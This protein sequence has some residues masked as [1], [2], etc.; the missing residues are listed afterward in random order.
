MIRRMARPRSP[1]TIASRP[2]FLLFKPGGVRAPVQVRVDADEFEALRLA[3]VEGLPH[4]DAAP[5]MGISRQTFGRVLASARR[6]VAAALVRGFALRFDA[7]PGGAAGPGHRLPCGIDALQ[8]ARCAEPL[9]Q[10]R[11]RAPRGWR[12]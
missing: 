4:G 1:R 2:S 10:L 6:K 7:A 3:D 9:V 12:A 5:R 8:C 11:K